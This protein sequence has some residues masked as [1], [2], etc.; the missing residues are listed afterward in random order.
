M[1][2]GARL[3]N[4]DIETRSSSA[5]DDDAVN[6]NSVLLFD[7]ISG[8][9]EGAKSSSSGDVNLR[10]PAGVSRLMTLDMVLTRAYSSALTST[11]L[12]DFYIPSLLVITT[13]HASSACLHVGKHD[14]S[15]FQC[16]LSR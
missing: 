3:R 15:A 10:G 12:S 4:V 8:P 5:S 2:P 1:N 9:V 7:D 13:V 6:L 16:T 14:L 11:P